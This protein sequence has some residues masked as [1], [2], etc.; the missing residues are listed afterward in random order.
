[1]QAYTY[2]EHIYIATWHVVN[3]YMASCLHS[4]TIVSAKALYNINIY[5]YNVP[6]EVDF[7]TRT[8]L[9]SEF[10]VVCKFSEDI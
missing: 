4:Y 1:M 3:G 6:D 10:L 8:C 2:K 9:A 7:A 5:S